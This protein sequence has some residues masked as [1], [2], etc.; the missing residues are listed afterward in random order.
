MRDE[1]LPLA[2]YTVWHDAGDR[3]HIHGCV[4]F[5]TYGRS[6]GPTKVIDL[7]VLLNLDLT[8][9]EAPPPDLC[10]AYTGLDEELARSFFSIPK[11]ERTF[12]NALAE[13][14]WDIERR[15]PVG[16]AA[17]L[18]H[19]NIGRH[20]SVAMAERLART[21]GHWDGFKAE[22]LHLDIEKT[23][24]EDVVRA[25]ARERRPED[26]SAQGRTGSKQP[27]QATSGTRVSE[28]RRKRATTTAYPMPPPREAVLHEKRATWAA[29][30]PREPY[31]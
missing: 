20:R 5:I 4:H 22:C 15:Q 31:P 8:G 28:V 3:A 7:P 1:D 6:Y 18:I 16:C 10:G 11:N 24:A 26:G 17:C 12:R 2:K 14:K 29:R 9:H 27:A 19:C 30:R 23:R 21:V 13:L 25:D